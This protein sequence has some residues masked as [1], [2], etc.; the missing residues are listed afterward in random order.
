MAQWMERRCLL[1]AAIGGTLLLLLMYGPLVVHPNQWIFSS[2]GDGLKN[3]YTFA[4]HIR[5][6]AA[7]TH[8]D[9]MNY[10]YGEHYLYIDGHPLPANVLKALSQI[11]PISPENSMAYLHWM[12]LFSI[13]FAV[14]CFT[15]VL[16][17]YRIRSWLAILFA[18]G[19]IALSPQI[20]RIDGHFALSYSM[21]LPLS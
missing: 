1:T 6:D 9:G 5:H 12:L 11:L 10:P 16:R 8:H 14:V 4:Y 3:Y 13:P 18:L 17:H 2:S 20:F 21:A 19:T 7:F 15:A